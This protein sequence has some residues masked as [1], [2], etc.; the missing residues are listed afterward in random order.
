MDPLTENTLTEITPDTTFLSPPRIDPVR[1]VAF[2][3][4][5]PRGEY[6]D[7]DTR[8]IVDDYCMVCERA[9]IDPLLVL[10]QMIH[11]TG[12]LSS[13]WA[14]RPRR[15]PAGLGVSG[16]PGAGLSFPSWQHSARAHVGRVL[17]YALT[18]EEAD[19]EQWSL[20][21]LAL[22]VRPLP[23]NY[24]GIARTLRGLTGTWATDPDYSNKLARIANNMLRG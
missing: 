2:M 8:M 22:Y 17:A 4:A 7:Y 11:E 21:G 9:K 24:R 16:K 23:T 18:D 19:A 12:N 10:A 5:R 13:W 20:I 3:Q 6:T 15:N 1:A 14:A